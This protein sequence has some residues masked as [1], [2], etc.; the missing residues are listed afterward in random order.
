VQRERVEKGRE[1]RAQTV[2]SFFASP[3]T[4]S[5]TQEIVSEAA[6]VLQTSLRDILREQLGQTYGVS[7]GLSQPLPQPGYGRVEVSFGAAPENIASMTDRVLTEI[8]RLQEEGP[9]ADL[10]QRAKEGAKRTFE[11]ALKQNNYWLRR[12]ATVHML[13]QNPAEIPSRL[14]RIDAVT[15]EA[16]RDAFKRYFPMER[17]TVVTLVP[18]PQA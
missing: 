14:E 16:L 3:S 1:P 11:T 12:L 17:Y 7:V 5:L 8:K 6:S 4:D 18:Q 2:I 9:S 13:S 15:I 10:T